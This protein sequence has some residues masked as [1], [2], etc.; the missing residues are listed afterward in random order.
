MANGRFIRPNHL[1][2]PHSANRFAASALY[3]APAPEVPETKRRHAAPAIPEIDPAP[4]PAPAPAVAECLLIDRQSGRTFKVAAP[5]G[6]IGRER[7]KVDV[8]LTDPNISRRHAE[9]KYDGRYWHI[10]DLRSTNGTLVNDI[11][12]DE[13]ILHSGD[14]ITV[15]LTNL[16]FR[17]N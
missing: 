11:D 5:S 2:P 4:A 17:E 15:G 13:C 14:L 7:G 10:V 16:E 6:V 12:I 1:T 3:F 9:L 8:A